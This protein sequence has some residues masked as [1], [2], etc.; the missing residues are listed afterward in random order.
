MRLLLLLLLTAASTGCASSGF[1]GSPAP[2]PGYFADTAAVSEPLAAVNDVLS[3]G[4]FTLVT[5]T[6]R[7]VDVRSIRVGSTTTTFR[8]P[9]DS[10][11][12]LPTSDLARVEAGRQGSGVAT[13]ALVG[14]V[15]GVVLTTAGLVSSNDMECGD[16]DIGWC[17]LG[18]AIKFGLIAGGVVLVL[19]GGAVGAGI[20]AIADP[21]KT[22]V[23]YEGPV[24]R[25][26]PEP[27]PTVLPNR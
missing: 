23:L 24:A 15:P 2:P 3:E 27:S 8:A 1:I 26:L 6:G 13:G 14:M 18:E 25:Y 12:Y 11:R 21:G 17:G 7:K 9:R 16:E 4:R 20:G 19:V 22:V 5:T 10:P